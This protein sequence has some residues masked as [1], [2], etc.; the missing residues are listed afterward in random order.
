M[1]ENHLKGNIAIPFYTELLKP[2]SP[3]KSLKLKTLPKTYFYK[4]NSFSALPNA[5][6]RSSNSSFINMFGE[7]VADM[8]QSGKV[9]E[10]FNAMMFSSK[11][12]VDEMTGYS[13]NGDKFESQDLDPLMPLN[14]FGECITLGL[15]NGNHIAKIK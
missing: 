2:D 10:M 4:W 6:K 1:R 3:I 7:I 13:P 5:G 14:E 12:V 15:K 11:E 8:D 9:Q